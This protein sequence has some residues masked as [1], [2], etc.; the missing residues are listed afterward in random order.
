M[1]QEESNHKCIF[2][3]DHDHYITLPYF[4]F[5]KILPI[6]QSNNIDLIRILFEIPSNAMIIKN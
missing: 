6:E 3:D 5:I 4:F 2:Y 1:A